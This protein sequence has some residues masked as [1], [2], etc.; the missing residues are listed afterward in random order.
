MKA[1]SLILSFMLLVSVQTFSQK[2]NVDP[3]QSKIKWT[4]KKI[5]GNSHNGE[6][7]L[8]SGLMELKNDQIVKGNFVV[9]MNTI[10]DL[11]LEDKSYNDKLVGHLKSDD[12]F[13]VQK[14]PTATFSV[15]KS[16]KFI[17]NKATITGNITIKGTTK[18]I[19]AVVIRSNDNFTTRLEIDRSQFDVRYGSNSFF[20][21]L[22]DKAIDNIF[23]L[24]IT[25]VT[26][27]MTAL[28]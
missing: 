14:Y 1:L 5:I 19:T 26:N 17:N 16:T 3:V 12:F 15:K 18:E 4:G 11:D 25:L 27:Q 21:N 23:V 20:D 2:L 22:G 24:E 9:D 28:R 7:K 8:K 13:G 6:I 10:T